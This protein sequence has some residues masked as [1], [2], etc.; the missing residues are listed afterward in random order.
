MLEAKGPVV[1]SLG[2]DDDPCSFTVM[3]VMI[4]FLKMMAFW[5]EVEA[6]FAF[7]SYLTTGIHH[8]ACNANDGLAFAIFLPCNSY[9][10]ASFKS[11]L[12]SVDQIQMLSISSIREC[13]LIWHVGSLCSIGHTIF[14]WC[15][16]WRS[17]KMW[18]STSCT[19]ILPEMMPFWWSMV[20]QYM[21]SLFITP[22]AIINI[23]NEPN[24]E[25]MAILDVHNLEIANTIID[26]Y[27]WMFP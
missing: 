23:R 18:C 10:H 22:H 14:V 5:N 12:L 15:N 4:F 26:C 20:V 9:S 25:A 24:Q 11:L 8:H 3:Y 19:T 7:Q 16:S 2:N 17:H 6:C 1:W 21:T 13:I 27:V